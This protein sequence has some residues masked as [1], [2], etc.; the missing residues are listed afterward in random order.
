MNEVLAVGLILAAALAA[1]R[2]AHR[3]GLPEVTAYL[4]VGILIGPASLDLVTHDA[5][6]T[7]EFLSEIALG[8]ILF[9][10]GAIFEADTFRRVGQTVLRIVTLETGLAFG[11]VFTLLVAV[12]TPPAVALLLGVIS[13]ETAPATT[14][15]VIREYDA[16]GPLTE[17]L[18]AVLALNN[19]VVLAAFGCAAAFLE[20]LAGRGDGGWASALH[21]GLHSLF[22]PTLGGIALGV[23]LGLLLDVAAAH[24]AEHGEGITLAMAAVLLAVGGAR[25]LDLSP[26]FTTLAMG[27]TMANA[28]RHGSILTNSLSRIDPPL[29][30]TFFVLAGAELQPAALAGMGAAGAVYVVA[31]PVGKMLGVRL[32]LRG[33]AEPE[34]VRAHLGRCIISSSSLA[35]GLSLQVRRLFPDL[36]GPV[37]AVALAAVLVFEVVGPL[38]ARR[39][40]I[41]AGEAGADTSPALT[42]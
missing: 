20:A 19:M 11:L 26:L 37:S 10:I 29:F 14:L 36:A 8:L 34:A 9:G 24:I 39:S 38:V 27:A 33:S 5:V 23:V 40:L 41:A 35:L 12:G 4:L 6:L 2:L 16:K 13:M 42:L 30:A 32:A 17:R 1:G 22:W 7:L 21:R 3:V 15:M 18:L 25:A 31:R 28:S